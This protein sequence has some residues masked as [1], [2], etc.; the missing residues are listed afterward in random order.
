[1]SASTRCAIFDLFSPRSS[2]THVTPQIFFPAATVDGV[3]IV[4]CIDLD[5]P[6]TG[7]AFLAPILHWLQTGLRASPSPGTT[8]GGESPNVELTAAGTAPLVHY[9]G[10]GP[11]PGSGPHRYLFLLYR[12][13]EDFD[14]KKVA[15]AA[16]GQQVGRLAR[17]RYDFAGLVRNGKFGQPVAGQWFVSN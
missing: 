12:Q 14:A 1:M 7:F 4:V 15:P 3:Y 5:A 16:E 17:M 10:A 11:P 6:F 9:A 13:P 8:T 2:D